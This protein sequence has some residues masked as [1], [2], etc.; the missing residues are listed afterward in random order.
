VKVIDSHKLSALPGEVK[1]LVR[2]GVYSLY[3][4][5]TSGAKYLL[6]TNTGEH[7]FLASDGSLVS[8]TKPDDLS[9][10]IDQVVSFSDAATA[11][12]MV[13]CA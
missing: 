6:L 12:V 9:S 7:Y 5:K 3:T 13:N 10:V 4:L 1:D 8:G 11:Q 2:D